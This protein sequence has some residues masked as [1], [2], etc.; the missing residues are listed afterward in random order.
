VNKC[1]FY[2]Q[3]SAFIITLCKRDAPFM[4]NGS[5]FC[6]KHAIRALKG[7]TWEVLEKRKHDS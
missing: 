3:G 6:D 5:S 1:V 2:I 4:V 7:V